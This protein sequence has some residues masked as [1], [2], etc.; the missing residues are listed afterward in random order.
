MHTKQ[1]ITRAILMA[2]AAGTIWAGVAAPL[3]AAAAPATGVVAM[4][5]DY[6]VHD[7]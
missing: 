6:N 7:G 5:P 1:L 3:A 2:V 4:Q